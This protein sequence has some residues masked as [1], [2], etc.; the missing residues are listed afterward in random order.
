VEP[1]ARREADAAETDAS[2]EEALRE[3][4]A[5]MAEKEDAMRKKNATLGGERYVPAIH[6]APRKR[7]GRRSAY[8]DI[9]PI[10]GLERD[11]ESA[12]DRAANLAIEQAI[13]NEKLARRASKR[14]VLFLAYL[15]LA[16]L[17]CG[18]AALF[19]WFPAASLAFLT[20]GGIFGTVYVLDGQIPAQRVPRRG[21]RPW[22]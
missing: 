18:A 17:A 13:L 10:E 5:R 20:L 22:E 2:E 4:L 14:R 3:E 11:V 6:A 9:D 12:K 19:L 16:A 8:R 15:S 21:P 7:T 1:L